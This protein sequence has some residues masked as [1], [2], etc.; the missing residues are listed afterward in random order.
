MPN[1]RPTDLRERSF[2]FACDIFDF[3]EEMSRDPGIPRRVAYQLFDAGSSVG[4]NLEEAKSA[5]SRRE[6]ASKNCISLKECR[7]AHY[8]LR[9]A[10]AKGLGNKERRTYL[11]GE[12]NELVSILTASVRRLQGGQG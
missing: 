10:A 4:S 7:E 9:I 11:L 3:C 8:W 5:Y 2:K 1:G 12:A 6:F